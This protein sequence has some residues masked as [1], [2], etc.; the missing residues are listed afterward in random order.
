MKL[1][2]GKTAL[3]TGASRGI[4]RAI[5]EKFADEGAN[6]ILTD[7]F[8]DENAQ[9]LVESLS[10][11][12]IKVK[13]YASD[14]SKYADAQKVVEELDD[15]LGEAVGRRRL[16]GEEEGARLHDAGRVGAQVLIERD[17]AQAV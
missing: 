12:G 10:A 2:E 17:D 4:G 7:L 15:E 9:A 5:A 6:L 13:M 3:I 1:L 8:Y 11:R 14:A 16:A